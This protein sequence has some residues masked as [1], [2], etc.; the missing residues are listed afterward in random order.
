MG[1][2]CFITLGQCGQQSVPDRYVIHFGSPVRNVTMLSV[3]A[4]LQNGPLVPEAITKV[5]SFGAGNRRL[6]CGAWES[7]PGL[8]EDEPRRTRRSTK[9]IQLRMDF[10]CRASCPSWFMP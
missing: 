4:R 10:L 1:G 6:H 8:K 2:I 9:K 7:G 5:T 3:W